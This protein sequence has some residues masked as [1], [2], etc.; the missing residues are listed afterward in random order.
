[1]SAVP[2]I[3]LSDQSL[4]RIGRVLSVASI[5]SA[6]IGMGLATWAG[7]LGES[8][9]TWTAV[10]SLMALIYGLLGLLLI[11]S[12]PRNPAVWLIVGAGVTSAFPAA[13]G[14]LW[15]ALAE[16][17]GVPADDIDTSGWPAGMA[18]LFALTYSLW[19]FANWG[20]MS[21]GLQLTPDGRPVTRRWS[22]LAIASLV[23]IAAV[24]LIMSRA[25]P[26]R[27]FDDAIEP[28]PILGP[29][30]MIGLVVL[31]PLS[32]ASLVV[33]YR[34]SDPDVRRRIRWVLY[35]GMWLVVAGILSLAFAGANAFTL[36]LYPV[37]GLAY[38]MAIWRDQLFD[39]DRLIARTLLYGMLAVFI[40]AVYVGVVF[41]VGSLLGRASADSSALSLAA[42]V[43]VAFAFQPARRRLEQAANRLVYGRRATPYEVLANL[44]ARLTRAETTSGMIDRMVGLLGEATG[45]E[46]VTVWRLHGEDASDR[47][48]VATWPDAATDPFALGVD[49][50]GSRFEIHEV[51]IE[52]A[53]ATL[54]TVAV[55]KRRGDDLTPTER[56]LLDDLAGSA[57]LV[58]D[59]AR[60]DAALAAQAEAL[61]SSRRRLVHAQ[62]EERQRLERQLDES[63]QRQLS[64]LA[65]GLDEGARTA[66]AAD[67]A[68]VGTQLE[69]LA[70]EVRTASDEITALAQGMYPMVLESEGL[71]AAVESLAAG[72]P[73]P[74]TVDGALAGAIDREVEL[75]VYFSIAEALTNV[76]KHAAATSASVHIDHGGR[77]LRFQVVDDGRGFDPE[78]TGGSSTGLVGLRDRIDTV[79]GTIAVRSQPGRGTTVSGWVPSTAL[80]TI[81]SRGGS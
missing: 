35:A 47:E 38:G 14:G 24:W 34:R 48:L 1:M 65:A 20:A 21:L 32:L 22:P 18:P 81:G 66:G 50:D 72:L 8:I 60:L 75:A 74:V 57:G 55:T 17:Q 19:P 52:R 67:L 61:T 70:A 40:G 73:I 53:A 63:T 27:D 11:R 7:R 3:P 29:L 80:A 68:M 49:T 78:R 15:D 45:A 2:S 71:V 69:A 37:L 79:G 76:V 23:L 28:Y 54:G 33:R 51:P 5:A 64:D 6:P 41:G 59:R 77:E 44:S 39:I 25:F 10:N 26:I 31:M 62:G 36:L 58:L 43:V 13:L 16:R 4:R 56:R 12:E 42:T 9:E 46:R 30:A